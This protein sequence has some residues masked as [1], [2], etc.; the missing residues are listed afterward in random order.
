MQVTLDGQRLFDGEKPEITINSV[1]RE[2]I[3]K[4]AAGLDGL[5]SIDLGRRGRKVEQKGTLRAK[6]KA[7]MEGKIDD[8]LSY[9]DGDSHTLVCDG[10]EFANLRMDSFKVGRERADSSGLSC[11]YEIDY[12]QLIV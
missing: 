3:E 2:Y 12:T 11:D 5:L 4:S 8:I 1:T 6:S 7:E 9:M 10:L